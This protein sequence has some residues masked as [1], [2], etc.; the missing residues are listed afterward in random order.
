MIEV[1]NRDAL[2][3]SNPA[4]LHLLRAQVSEQRISLPVRGPLSF[5]RMK[6]VTGVPAG[7]DGRAYSV[8]RLRVLDTLI[9]RLSTARGERLQTPELD[10]STD[11]DALIERYSR[12]LY[13]AVR[14]AETGPYAG[15]IGSGSAD[16]GLYLNL[17]V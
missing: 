11:L 15:R 14:A 3:F 7:E 5:V 1:V 17:L 13:E 6:H 9:D 2:K 4:S 8:F 16:L 10:E 12:Q